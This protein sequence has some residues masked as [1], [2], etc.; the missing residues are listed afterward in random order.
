METE[1]LLEQQQYRPG[2][3]RYP[4]YNAKELMSICEE[5]Q[6]SIAQVALMNECAWT[7]QGSSRSLVN[8]LVCGFGF[9]LPFISVALLCLRL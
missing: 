7:P 3:P 1:R 9:L 6:L 5:Q 8:G 4:F 2:I